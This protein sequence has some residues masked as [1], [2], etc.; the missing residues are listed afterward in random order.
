MN[1][2]NFKW[3]TYVIVAVTLGTIALQIYWNHKNYL[4]NKQQLVNDVQFC[5]D[6]AVE[7]YYADLAESSTVSLAFQSQN[8]DSLQSSKADSIF[9]QSSLIRSQHLS[10]NMNKLMLDSIET[11]NTNDLTIIKI[12][13][14]DTIISNNVG[15][16]RMPEHFQFNTPESVDISFDSINRGYLHSLTSRVL[17]SLADTNLQLNKI[18]SLF[19][20]QLN[21]K[22]IDID[23][24]LSYRS[25]FHDSTAINQKIISSAQLSTNSSSPYLHNGDS[26]NVFYNNPTRTILKRILA[27]I[28]LSTLLVLAVITILFYQLYIIKRQKQLAEVKNDLISNITHEFKTPISTIGVAIESIR[29]FNIINDQKKTKAYLNMSSAQLE[30]LNVMVEKLLETATLDSKYLAL[31]KESTDLVELLENC[32]E[33][34]V[35]YLEGKKISYVKPS[36][37][38]MIAID[39]FHFEN[40]ISNIIDNAVKYGGNDI[41]IE[42][43]A[44]DQVVKISISDSGNSLTKGQKE[45]V[46]EK[47]YRV[48]K[49]NTHDVK[50]FGIGL[51]YTKKIIE[52]H[53]GNISLDNQSKTTKFIISIP[54]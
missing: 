38:V 8:S 19:K 18:D 43:K 33:K 3:F 44:T 46:F 45:R 28:I 13:N 4:I 9:L 31:Q 52:N 50:G 36:E 20:I 12:I 17:I 26:L 49:G 53:G 11:A 22:Q 1:N 47:F 15:E 48:P 39:M 16:S 25:K 30:K 34:H 41:R 5:L 14:G 27:S 2:Q 6:N 21:S 51:Y 40:A 29:D 7:Y 32:I 23:Y 35:L 24:G 10:N 54:I 37:P 42:L